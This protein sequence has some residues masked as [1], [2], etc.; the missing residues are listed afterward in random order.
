[1]LLLAVFGFLPLLAADQESEEALKAFAKA[2]NTPNA[3]ARA[4]AVGTLAHTQTI[5]IMS[6][7]AELLAADEPPVRIAAAKGL[8]DF[9]E[10]KPKAAAALMEG[11]A[12]NSKEFDVAAAILMALGTLGEESALAIIHQHFASKDAKDK[13]HLIPKAAI[14]AAGLA[15]NRES[16]HVLLDLAKELEKAEGTNANTNT[17]TKGSKG[18]GGGVRGIPGGGTNPQKDRAKALQPVIVKAM[19]AITKEKWATIKE[20]E[21]WWEKRQATFVVPK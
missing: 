13:D 10:N 8:G 5:P 19:Q 17:N 9:T 20:W 11:M 7:L 4:T 3:S 6:K 15:R 12:V 21:V 2:Y 14:Q 1:M 16:I 18:S